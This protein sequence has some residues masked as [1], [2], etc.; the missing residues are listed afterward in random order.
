M[1]TIRAFTAPKFTTRLRHVDIHRHWLRQEISKGTINI[2]WV[3]STK[4]LADGLTKQLTP[5]K[6]E[7]FL[8]LLGLTEHIAKK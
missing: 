3:S 8:K 6:H 5:Q 4:I 1:Q 2:A 7:E